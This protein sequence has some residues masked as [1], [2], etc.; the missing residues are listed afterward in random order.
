MSAVRQL[1]DQCYITTS[2]ELFRLNT[3]CGFQRRV[4]FCLRGFLLE[5]NRAAATFAT[6]SS[7][8]FYCGASPVHHIHCRW[9]ANSILNEVSLN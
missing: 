1:T 3:R 8:F 9:S 2:D 7:S 4:F 5:I 6:M